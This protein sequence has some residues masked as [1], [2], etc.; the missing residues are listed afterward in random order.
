M[1]K[2]ENEDT[3]DIEEVEEGEEVEEEPEPETK[4]KSKKKAPKKKK[5]EK[6]P[7]AGRDRDEYIAKLIRENEG[8]KK[9]ES[10]MQKVLGDI[11]AEKRAE[12]VKLVPEQHREYAESLEMDA[13]SKV[14][15]ILGE[16]KDADDKKKIVEGV[17]EE[18][19]DQKPDNED[20]TGSKNPFEGF[21]NKS[22]VVKPLV[23]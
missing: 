7:E 10:E 13:L 23:K 22:D 9:R 12:L 21:F 4:P 11:E 6:A 17:A 20:A 15:S 8:L 19:T 2:D 5:A 18:T 14:V 1:T 16:K 3:E